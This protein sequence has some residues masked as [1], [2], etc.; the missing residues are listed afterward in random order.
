MGET[1]DAEQWLLRIAELGDA[2]A[3]DTLAHIHDERGEVSAA[4]EWR[5]KA[6][7]LADANLTRNGRT[8]VKA[9]GESAVLRYVRIIEEHADHVATQGDTATADDWRQRAAA[10]LPTRSP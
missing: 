8:L 7:N 6:A 1:P 3:A 4:A 9:Y 2:R 10:H 5:S